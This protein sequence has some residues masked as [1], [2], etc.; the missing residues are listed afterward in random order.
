VERTAVWRGPWRRRD[1]VVG[2]EDLSAGD[3]GQAEGASDDALTHG[4]KVR[5]QAPKRKEQGQRRA[6]RRGKTGAPCP[7]A[8]GRADPKPAICV[9]AAGF[10]V[11]PS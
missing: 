8:Y 1:S 9:A 11:R 6:G 7:N 4:G 10:M 2:T 3:D 5:D